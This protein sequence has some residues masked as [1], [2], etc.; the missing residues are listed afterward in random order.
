MK[1]LSLF[2]LV[3]LTALQLSAHRMLPSMAQFLPENPVIL[4]AG[5]YDGEDAL[6]M[7][8]VWPKSTIHTFEPIPLLFLKTKAKT[9]NCKN[10]TCYQMALSNQSGRAQL[11]ISSDPENDISRS[12][13]LL[14][15]KEHLKLYPDVKFNK[16]I[17][18][19]TINLDEWSQLNNINHVDM[20]WLD[21]QGAELDALKGAPNLLKTVKVVFIKI[22]LLETYKNVPHYA[23]VRSWLESKG[24]T[25]IF[26]ETCGAAKAEG[27]ALFIRTL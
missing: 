10:I 13:S 7:S 20:M 12:S 17:E 24:F 11:Y 25:M 15:P 1:K 18:V 5:S 22:A 6:N 23:V 16:S 9:F 27:Y 8:Q 3:S 19:Q 26:E 21:M 2:L 4:A 14:E